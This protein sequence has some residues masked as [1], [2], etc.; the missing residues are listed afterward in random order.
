MKIHE[1]LNE[2]INF[3]RDKHKKAYISSFLQDFHLKLKVLPKTQYFKELLKRDYY[4]KINEL[5]W[6]YDDMKSFLKNYITSK[7]RNLK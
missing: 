5:D 4:S 6:Y 2:K 7:I 1:I 3:I